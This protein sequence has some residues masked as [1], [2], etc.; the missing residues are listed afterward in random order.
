[1]KPFIRMKNSNFSF[2]AL[3]LLSLLLAC[4]FFTGEGTITGSSVE[5]SDAQPINNLPIGAKVMDPSWQWEFR[6]LPYYTFQTGDVTRPVTWIVVAKDHYGQG[7]GVTLLSESV[8]GSYTFDNSTNRGSTNGSNHWGN[9]GNPNANHGLQLWLNSTGIHAGEG[10]YHAMPESFKSN[11]LTTVVPCR[12]HPSGASYTTQNNVFIPSYKELNMTEGETH[13]FM[14]GSVFPYFEN[15]GNADRIARME[16]KGEVPYHYWTRDPYKT[17][18]TSVATISQVGDWSGAYAR[19]E[20]VFVRPVVNLKP[21]TQVSAMTNADGAY[22]LLEIP[23]DPDPDPSKPGTP[24]LSSPSHGQIVQGSSVAL[25][26]APVTGATHYAVWIYNLTKDEKVIFTE[27]TEETSYTHE[28]LTDNGD[29][30]AWSVVASDAQAGTWGDFATPIAFINGSDKDL[31]PP[32]LTSPN[33][34]GTVTG[35]QVLL[36]WEAP[37]GADFYTILV[38]DLDTGEYVDGYDG[39]QLFSG[40]SHLVSGLSGGATTYYWTVSAADSRVPGLFSDYAFPRLF[41]NK[42]AL[43]L[44]KQE[45]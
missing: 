39:S 42:Q 34:L 17:N 24:N 43:R 28:G 13:V 16:G 41:V 25:N 14:S 38:A 20:H 31:L 11:I 5:A 19:T 45:E 36:Q 10:F 44:Q 6:A 23:P 1:M 22:E 9:S 18:P 7:S 4:I 3:L 30:Y 27:P 12:T 15:A 8:I 35:S 29:I 40:T 37:Q 32:T 26:W 21:G 33:H 2:A